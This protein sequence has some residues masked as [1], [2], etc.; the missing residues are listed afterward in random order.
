MAEALEIKL[1]QSF[2]D[3]LEEIKESSEERNDNRSD[4]DFYAKN[5]LNGGNIQ[6]VAPTFTSQL[7]KG[8]EDIGAAIFKGGTKIFF[9]YWDKIKKQEEYKKNR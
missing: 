8:Y 2:F 9:E 1:P 4:S 6:K 7:A 5:I 3:A